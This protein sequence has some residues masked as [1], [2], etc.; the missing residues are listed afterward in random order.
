LV[1]KNKCIEP[2]YFD[3]KPR[4]QDHHQHTRLEYDTIVSKKVLL[5]TS[6]SLLIGQY[7]ES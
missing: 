4:H 3:K 2:G 6:K 7:Y 1:N 5:D